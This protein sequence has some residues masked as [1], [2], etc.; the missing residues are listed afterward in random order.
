MCTLIFVGSLSTAGG[1]LTK[2]PRPRAGCSGRD[3]H[4][5]AVAH[6]HVGGVP[7]AFAR[8]PFAALEHLVQLLVLQAQLILL[9]NRQRAG[10]YKQKPPRLA[11]PISFVHRKQWFYRFEV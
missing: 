3:A 2:C 9:G 5:W 7:L 10:R 4:D 11:R 1:T 8:R 6:E